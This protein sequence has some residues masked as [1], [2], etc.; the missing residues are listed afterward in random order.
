M[1][2]QTLEPLLCVSILAKVIVDVK[3]VT[4]KCE[5]C[6]HLL[7]MTPEIDKCNAIFDCNHPCGKPYPFTIESCPSCCSLYPPIQTICCNAPH[8]NKISVTSVKTVK[9]KLNTSPS[10]E[11]RTSHT[12]S[13]TS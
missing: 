5:V 4:V 13:A 8:N 10:G 12:R 9:Q 6:D 3:G 2:L 7:A 11:N 1:K